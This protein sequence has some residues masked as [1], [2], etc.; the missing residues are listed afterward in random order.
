MSIKRAVWLAA[1]A[2]LTTSS[3]ALAQRWGREAFPRSGAC[4]YK[5][6][7]F[8]GEY[9][10]VRAGDDLSAVPRD[11]NDEISSLRVIGR[12]EV[13]VFKD[14]R[15]QGRSSRFEN[16]IRNLKREGWDDAISSIRV[17]P[18]GE[19]GFGRFGRTEDP[20]RIVLRAY[21]DVL[22]R[23]PDASGMRTYRS[24]IIDQGWTEADVRE[25]LRRSPEYR[26]RTTMTYPKAQ[27]IVRQAYL[28]V[29]RREPDP[30]SR[31]YVERV[32]RD[33]WSQQDVER[34][35]RNSPEYKKR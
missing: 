31:A 21:Q 8:S 26:E 12:V 13:F 16:D 25:D 30:G 14:V 2:V 11:M 35:L 19:S 3:S 34:E 4:F 5:D 10:C 24:H 18:A 15:F 33:H 27:E 20:E 6:P 32:M 7:N 1:F 22:G 29:L 9:F 23:E 28:A 17:R